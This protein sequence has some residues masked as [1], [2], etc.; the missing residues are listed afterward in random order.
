MNPDQAGIGDDKPDDLWDPSIE[1]VGAIDVDE[2]MMEGKGSVRIFHS[3]FPRSGDC[4]LTLPDVATRQYFVAEEWKPHGIAAWYQKFRGT[5]RAPMNLRDF[6]FDRQSIRVNF[7]SK[8]YGADMCT[9]VNYTD[10]EMIKV[11]S[12]KVH[13]TEWKLTSLAEVRSVLEFNE[14]DKRDVSIVEVELHFKRLTGYYLKNIVGLL[15][16]L[17][18]I[19]W[20]MCVDSELTILPTFLTFS[21]S[22]GILCHHM[23]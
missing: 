15:C 17:A 13:L 18:V 4:C 9:F 8:F 5:I 14:E 3:A 6:P 7:G 2:V 11:F 22:T 20:A 16:I 12:N 19:S 23:S 21:S 1:I 10:P